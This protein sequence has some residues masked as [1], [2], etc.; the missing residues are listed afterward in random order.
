MR[1]AD[2]RKRVRVHPI[3]LSKKPKL[4]LATLN[5]V[6]ALDLILDEELDLN[7]EEEITCVMNIP[8][9]NVPTLHL[10]PPIYGALEP[11]QLPKI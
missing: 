7:T 5:Q 1:Y 3:M 4:E 8:M 2:K 9:S 10:V 6:K 11:S